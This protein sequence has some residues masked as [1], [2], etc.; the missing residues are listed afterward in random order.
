LH[1]NRLYALS[2]KQKLI[3]YESRETKFI[4]VYQTDV[5]N[6]VVLKG[7]G[8]AH[9][10]QESDAGAPSEAFHFDIVLK[11]RDFNIVATM[12]IDLARK[13]MDQLQVKLL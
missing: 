2:G 11:G 5:S 10:D 13:L 1:P 6:S 8:A 4:K 7:L 12:D 3:M 9:P